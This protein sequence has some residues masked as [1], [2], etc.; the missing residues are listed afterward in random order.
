M[1]VFISI[2]VGTVYAL[3]TFG[4]LGSSHNKYCLANQVDYHPYA[5]SNQVEMVNYMKL[6]GAENVT[7]KFDTVIRYGFFSNLIFLIFQI[8]KMSVNQR[9]KKDINPGLI[10]M[11]GCVS[12]VWVVQFILLAVYR[13]SHTGLVCSGDYASDLYIASNM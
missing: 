8:W 6:A 2:G 7:S 13:F 4:V 9:L 5:Y 11:E 12:I 3:Y 10:C 1:S